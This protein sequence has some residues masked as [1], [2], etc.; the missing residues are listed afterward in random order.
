MFPKITLVAGLL[1]G[2]SA[3]ALA[4]SAL[5]LDVG[6]GYTCH[7]DERRYHGGYGELGVGLSGPSAYGFRGGFRWSEYRS[8]GLSAR[9][10]S[11]TGHG[12]YQLDYFHYVPWMGLGLITHLPTEEL[13]EEPVIGLSVQF[14]VRR[15]LDPNW[16]VG[17]L[18]DISTG[19]TGDFPGLT[20]VGIRI[21]Y[22][23]ALEDP[24]DP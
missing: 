19:A 15:L 13:S 2:L 12:I 23:P 7:K 10:H 16:A 3:S 9:Q 18:T 14:G 5:V 20:T 22:T 21:S 11:L 6:V 24:F 1:F 4:E 17:A 8:K